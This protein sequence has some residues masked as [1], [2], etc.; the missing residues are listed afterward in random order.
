[1]KKNTLSVVD[2]KKMKLIQARKFEEHGLQHFTVTPGGAATAAAAAAR[3]GGI[4]PAP[5]KWRLVR[6]PMVIARIENA[7]H[8]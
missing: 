4:E 7:P 1:M 3:K 5:K 8:I 2:T 6:P